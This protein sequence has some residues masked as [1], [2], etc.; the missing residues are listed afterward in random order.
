M[1]VGGALGGQQP[2]LARPLDV[3]VGGRLGEDARLG[4]RIDE[5][6]L[7][8]DLPEVVAARLRA[9]RGADAVRERMPAHALV[10]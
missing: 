7:T 3:F 9:L 5:G 6:V 1:L 10:I 4:E 8:A 2:E